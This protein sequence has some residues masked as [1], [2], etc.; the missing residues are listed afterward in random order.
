ML[1]LYYLGAVMFGLP[2]IFGAV[3][4]FTGAEAASD[5]LGLLPLAVLF[6]VF[7]ALIYGHKKRLATHHKPDA[8]SKNPL[9]KWDQDLIPKW[10]GHAR[11]IEFTY[12]DNNGNKTRRQV[13]VTKVVVNSDGEY[14]LFG[15][16]YLRDEDRHFKAER[17]NSMILEKSKRSHVF[18][19]IGKLDA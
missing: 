11:T 4:L 19:W 6:G 17:I 16:C 1:A 8:K 9:R 15:H 5:W 13:G 18:D 3:G 7:V 10:Q 14:Y 2:M 12:E